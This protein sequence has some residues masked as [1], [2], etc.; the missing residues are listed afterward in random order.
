MKER[1]HTHL[2]GDSYPPQAHI[3]RDLCIDV[4]TTGPDCAFIQ[5]P[6][7]QAICSPRKT[8]HVGVM[9]T[10]VDVLAGILSI[11]AISP[12]WLSTANLTIHM[13]CEV[14]QGQVFA[15]GRI[16]RS[17][18]T[19]VVVGAEIRSTDEAISGKPPA[20]VAMITFSR[21]PGKHSN[22]HQTLAV[23][24]IQTERFSLGQKR[25]TQPLVEK[26]GIQIIDG[27]TGQLAVELSD[28]I[29]NSLGSLQGGITAL[30][31]E[32]AGEHA[33]GAATGDVW[34]TQDLSIHYMSPGT[35]GPFQSKAEVLRVDRRS[36]LVRV[37]VIDH[38]DHD[39]LMAI[40]FNS[41]ISPVPNG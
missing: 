15:D 35:V 14:Q 29:R 36:A 18:R 25:M 3:L 33:A 30:L 16:L 2:V 37:H 23:N 31:A 8:L 7:T 21:L 24:K 11:R 38:G 13:R 40:G 10:L 6:V 1:A 19:S 32:I 28:Y 4:N 22:H 41:L 26:I 9:A 27:P 17:G 39:R 5:A 12:D 34:Q 20:G